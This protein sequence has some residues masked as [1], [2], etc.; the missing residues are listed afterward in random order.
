MNEEY[1]GR[2]HQRQD[3]EKVR[4]D[5]TAQ[6]SFLVHPTTFIEYERLVLI[7]INIGVNQFGG[8]FVQLD[9]K[10]FQ[11]RHIVSFEIRYIIDS[12]C[13]SDLGR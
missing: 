5:W 9:Q 4:Q 11:S 7:R 6:L 8:S 3:C 13:N 1:V 12:A 2:I 10:D